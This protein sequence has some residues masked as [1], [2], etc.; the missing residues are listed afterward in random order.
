MQQKVYQKFEQNLHFYSGHDA[1]IATMMQTLGVYDEILPP[2]GS[3]LIFE[4]R[5]KEFEHYVTVCFGT[6][7]HC[8]S[9]NFVY[10]PIT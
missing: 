5:Q 1:T 3:A 7:S 4:L 6:V 9:E 10:F 2:Y 8:S